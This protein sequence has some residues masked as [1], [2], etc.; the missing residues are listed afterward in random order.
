MP[1]I[2][3]YL[4]LKEDELIHKMSSEKNISKSDVI[5]EIIRK[6][7]EKKNDIKK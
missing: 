2:Q 4:G 6:Y 7:L 1:L 3:I 5:Q